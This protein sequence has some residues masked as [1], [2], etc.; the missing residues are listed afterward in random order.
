MLGKFTNELIN[1]LII[2]FQKTENQEKIITHII[3]PTIYHILDRLYP[4][5]FF[6]SAIFILILLIAISILLLIIREK[7]VF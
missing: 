3:D 2:E 1:K 4:Y 5:I 6:T 7:Y